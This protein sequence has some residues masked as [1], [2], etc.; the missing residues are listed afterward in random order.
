MSESENDDLFDFE[1]DMDDVE[2][3][4]GGPI[5]AGLYRAQVEE[6]SKEKTNDGKGLYIKVQFNVTD[7]VQTGRK[8]WEMY[9]VKNGGENA[10]KV[11]NIGK[12]H[13]KALFN[14]CG[15]NIKIFNDPSAM[16]GLECLVKLRVKSEEGYEDKNVISSYKPL[17]DEVPGTG[18]EG[19]PEKAGEVPLDA[20]GNPV[21]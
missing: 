14:A 16:V 9:N 20:D 5:P 8:F 7:D 17:P 6:A 10:K 18:Q 4:Q 19:V 15:A 12:G 13:L 3:V 2:E 21:F 1:F 11:V